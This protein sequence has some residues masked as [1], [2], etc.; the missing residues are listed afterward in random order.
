[1]GGGGHQQRGVALLH[2]RIVRGD[3]ALCKGV[4]FSRSWGDRI[5]AQYLASG[6]AVRNFFPGK[7]LGRTAALLSLVLLVLGWVYGV[8][9]AL[10]RFGGTMLRRLVPTGET[11]EQEFQRCPFDCRVIHACGEL[12]VPFVV[13]LKKIDPC[14]RAKLRQATRYF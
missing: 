9:T 12:R 7:L 8:N 5:D 2:R 11:K 10:S 14:P 6:D 4:A 3:V 13:Y 1:M